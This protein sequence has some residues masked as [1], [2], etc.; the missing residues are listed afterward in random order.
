MTCTICEVA[1]YDDRLPT[2]CVG[3]INVFFME[4][5]Q[6]PWQQSALNKELKPSLGS[7]PLVHHHFP[8]LTPTSVA[9]GKLPKKLGPRVEVIQRG[10]HVCSDEEG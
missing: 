7:R 10:Y 3:F 4:H 9:T 5:N 2:G 8:G 6:Q 1:P